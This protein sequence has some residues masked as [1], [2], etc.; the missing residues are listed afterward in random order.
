MM[1]KNRPNFKRI[2]K[3]LLKLKYPEKT[4]DCNNIL[5]KE[6]LT[7]YNLIVLNKI[8]FGDQTHNQKPPQ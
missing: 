7:N 1:N 3:D 4:K 5:D 2:Y 6:Q 8:I